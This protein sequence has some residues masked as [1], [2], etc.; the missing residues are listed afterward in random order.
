MAP[1][2][3]LE[4]DHIKPVAEGG[5]NNILNLI[6]ACRDCNRGKG[7]ERIGVN[8]ELKKQQD[9][10]KDFAEKKEQL[11]MMAI[12]REQL[13]ELEEQQIDVI[14]AYVQQVTQWSFSD[15]GRTKIR[16]LIKQFGFHAVN[17]ATEISFDRYFDGSE[18][19]W[20]EAFRKIGGVCYNRKKDGIDD[21]NI[22]NDTDVLLD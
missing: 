13:L 18:E 9:Q 3:I 4:I 14:E 15:Y 6:T 7:K 22:Q 21:G 10:L 8:A 2:V 5:D 20:N 17:V 16:K 12:W 11:A 19:S 1:D